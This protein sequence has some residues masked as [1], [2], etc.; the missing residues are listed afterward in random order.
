M[1]AVN[2][3]TTY[4]EGGNSPASHAALVTPDDA[5]DLAFVSR[6]LLIGTAGALK[7]TTLGGETLVI[8]AVPAGILPLRV[9]RVWSGS[10]T[11]AQIVSLW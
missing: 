5:N 10:T 4:G 11:A 1:A 3:Q 2:S 7:V 8:A 9:T 6:A